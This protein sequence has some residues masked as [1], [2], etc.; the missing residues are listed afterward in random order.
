[1]TDTA[2]DP[3]ADALEIAPHELSRGYT[4]AE[5]PRWHDGA[6]W[7]SDMYTHRIVRLD[8]AGNPETMVDL[9]ARTSVNGTEV[10]PGGFGWL[11]DGRLIVTS[12]HERLVLAF[13]GEHLVE[14]ADLREL[15][16]GPINDMVVDADG[17][18]YVTQLGFELFEG[19][20]PKD[21]DLLVVEP[22]GSARALTELGG[23]AGANGIAVSADGS[24]VVTAEAFANRITVLDRDEHGHLSGRRVF[25]STPSLPDGICLD[26]D[27]GVWAG[28]PAVPAVAR[29]VE[30]GAI[31]DI[32]RFDAGQALPPACVL[33]GP[34][35]RTLFVCA[36]LDVMDF[37]ESRRN[38]NGTVWTAGVR[39]SGGNNRP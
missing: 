27:G 17:R 35:R 29:L 3:F 28:L 13:D 31:T 33:G 11:P 1:M 4:W 38:R 22:D 30:G 21:S 15:A 25:A 18:A 20:A 16:T 24:R 2:V 12:M 7:F 39:A 37:E 34:D 9:A 19:E 23:F 36:G 8:A 32:V 10:I 14:H 5:C 6:F 26:D